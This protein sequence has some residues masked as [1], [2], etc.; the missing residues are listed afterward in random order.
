MNSSKDS[1]LDAEDSLYMALEKI[2]EGLNDLDRFK[3]ASSSLDQASQKSTE[4]L[5]A[6]RDASKLL[7][8][9]ATNLSEKS[10]ANFEQHLVDVN[11][12]MQRL[13]A[14]LVPKLNETTALVGKHFENLHKTRKA[15]REVLDQLASRVDTH[16]K[17]AQEVIESQKAAIDLF[18]RQASGNFDQTQRQLR[19]IKIFSLLGSVV[20]VGL[21]GIVGYNFFR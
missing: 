15:D 11:R 16:I 10:L 18:A 17:E 8:T 5:D 21:L 19:L 7:E 1:G 2:Q 9:A 3:T 13:G 12:S 6:L 20:L 14:D 4:I